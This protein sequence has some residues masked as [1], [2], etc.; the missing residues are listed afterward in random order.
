MYEYSIPPLMPGPGRPRSR[1]PRAVV[2]LR[3]DPRDLRAWQA[4]GEDWRQRMVELLEARIGPRRKHRRTPG[5][6]IRH[7]L[8]PPA[9]ATLYAGDALDVLKQL[10]RSKR[11]VDA[12]ITDPPYGQGYRS[13]HR[14]DTGGPWGKYTYGENFR[15][16][17]GDDRPFDPKPWLAFSRSGRKLIL[18]GANYYANR[19]PGARC[20]L[21]WDKRE[22]ATSNQQADAELAWTNLDEPAR[23]YSHLWMG[24]IRRGEENIAKG[25]RKLH[26]NQKPV[27]LMD[28]CLT[29]AEVRAGATVFDPYMGSGTLGI[30]CLRRG[31]HYVGAEIDPGYFRIAESRIRQEIER[32]DSGATMTCIGK[33]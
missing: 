4:L 23:V 17:A 13:H 10:H 29:V 18:W 14:E 20:W 2:S 6:T 8:P 27:A 3:L 5:E 33:T 30:A 1:H 25:G 32:L 12:V 22:G 31:I 26:P 15:P 24:L 7:P 9:T 11:V 28:W 16:I 21:V 19:L